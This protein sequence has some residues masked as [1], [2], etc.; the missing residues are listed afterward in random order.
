MSWAIGKKERCV[1][2]DWRSRPCLQSLL[3]RSWLYPSFSLMCSGR[4]FSTAITPSCKGWLSVLLGILLFFG[5]KAPGSRRSSYLFYTSP[6]L[7]LF[8]VIVI[9]A[10]TVETLLLL[11]TVRI[12]CP[13]DR[14]WRGRRVCFGFLNYSFYIFQLI[15]ILSFIFISPVEHGSCKIMNCSYF[16]GEMGQ[17]EINA[18]SWR[19]E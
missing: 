18:I 10:V 14:W 15:W 16:W 13:I 19:A 4:C 8:Q 6:R 12:R 7:K 9:R 5:S 17:A 11:L 1:N 2:R 3:Y